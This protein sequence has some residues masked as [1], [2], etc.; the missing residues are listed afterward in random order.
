MEVTPDEKLNG[1]RELSVYHNML[2]RCKWYQYS[3]K[4]EIKTLIQVVRRIYEI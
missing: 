1:L 3:K 2:R 4:R